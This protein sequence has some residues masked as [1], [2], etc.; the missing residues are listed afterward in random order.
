MVYRDPHDVLRT[1]EKEVVEHLAAVGRESADLAAERRRLEAELARI[2][3]LLDP[4]KMTTALLERTVIA[5][6][7]SEAWEGM[8]GDNCAR[9]SAQSAERTSSTSPRWHGTKPS[10]SSWKTRVLACGSIA[11][12]MGPSSRPIAPSE[13]ARNDGWPYS[14]VRP[15]SPWVSPRARASRPGQRPSSRSPL[16][17]IA[18]L[19][20]RRWGS[21]IALK[22]PARAQRLGMNR[23]FGAI[24]GESSAVPAAACSAVEIAAPVGPTVKIVRPVPGAAAVP[25]TSSVAAMPPDS[26]VVRPAPFAE[27]RVPSVAGDRHDLRARP[28]RR[29]ERGLLGRCTAFAACKAAEDEPGGQSR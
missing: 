12:P 13:A 17:R 10:A 24:Y 15:S 14:G 1:R 28:S 3:S 7:C 18:W 9:N 22:R 6:P 20:R 8:S 21:E 26:M 25:C 19:A 2:R 29:S 5:S 11:A 23:H 16:R 27:P 4:S